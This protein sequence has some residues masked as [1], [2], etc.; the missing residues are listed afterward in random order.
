MREEKSFLERAFFLREK[1]IDKQ[2]FTCDNYAVIDYGVI[3]TEADKW[4]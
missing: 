4:H 3:I 2:S 1:N